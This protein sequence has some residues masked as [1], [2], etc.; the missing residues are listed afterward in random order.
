MFTLLLPLSSISAASLEGES[1][2]PIESTMDHSAAHPE[3]TSPLGDEQHASVEQSK[4]PKSKSPYDRAHKHIE[5]YLTGDNT[6]PAFSEAC[7]KE[8]VM[9]SKNIGKMKVSVSEK[10]LIPPRYPKW[11][12]NAFTSALVIHAIPFP[13]PWSFVHVLYHGFNAAQARLPAS[14]TALE[15]IDPVVYRNYYNFGGKYEGSV[16]APHFPVYFVG[17]DGRRKLELAVGAGFPEKHDSLV[18][19]AK[20]L[21]EGSHEVTTVILVSIEESP[22]CLSPLRIISD[23]E[24]KQ[25]VLPCDHVRTKEDFGPVVYKR[26][27]WVGRITMIWMGVWRKD[28]LSGLA[29][30][31]WDRMDLLPYAAPPQLEFKLSDFISNPQNDIPITFNCMAKN[32]FKKWTGVRG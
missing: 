29:T 22:A 1:D 4:L 7:W 27:V 31:N 17:T 30:R 23:E 12:Y 6:V 13:L 21:L 18:Q 26:L 32:D 19:D 9:I 16:K 5:G 24:I 3:S 28:P 10:R 8:C 14:E 2:L 25:L 11:T 15:T 20:L